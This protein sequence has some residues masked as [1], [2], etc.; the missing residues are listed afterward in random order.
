MVVRAQR[1][2]AVGGQR[3]GE[4]EYALDA[5]DVLVRV[6]DEVAPGRQR[7]GVPGPRRPARLGGDGAQPLCLAPF[8]RVAPCGL[9]VV[10]GLRPR[11]GFEVEGGFGGCLLYT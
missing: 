5:A 2:E 4:V 10:F 11:Q 8:Q 1:P 6:L 3:V 7:G 9:G